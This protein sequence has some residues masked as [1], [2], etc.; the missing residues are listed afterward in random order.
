MSESAFSH[1]F[2]KRTGM[3]YINYVNNQR[4]AKA[5]TLL[6]ETTLSAAEICYDCGFNNKSNFIRIFNKKKGMTPIEYRK[7]ITQMLIKY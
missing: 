6:A 5:C 1:F 7:F 3:S 4:V 2:K